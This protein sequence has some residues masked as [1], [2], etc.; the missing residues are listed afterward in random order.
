MRENVETVWIRR[1]P[2]LKKRAKAA[3]SLEGVTF[4]DFIADAILARVL[5]VESKNFQ[6]GG[7][8]GNQCVSG[9]DK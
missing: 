6:S 7:S 8:Q 3:A 4:A 2:K 9:G 5:E 1:D